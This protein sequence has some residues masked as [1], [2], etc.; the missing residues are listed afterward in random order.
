MLIILILTIINN[1]LVKINL[2]ILKVI[3][4]NKNAVSWDIKSK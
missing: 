3:N 4:N 1:Y 2:I